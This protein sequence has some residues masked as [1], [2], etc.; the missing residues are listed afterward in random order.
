MMQKGNIRS[1]PGSVGQLGK[2]GAIKQSARQ[3]LDFD[4]E[5]VED[6]FI[7]SPNLAR[8]CEVSAATIL[9]Y[10]YLAYIA[11]PAEERRLFRLIRERK[12]KSIVELGI[13]DGSRACR[14][15]DLASRLSG[16]SIRYAGIDLFEARQDTA[17]GLRYKDAHQLLK[18]TGAKARLVP[19][20]PLTALSRAANELR[21]TDLLIIAADQNPQSLQQAWFYLP[22][23]LAPEGIVCQQQTSAD[24]QSVY[25]VLSAQQ[26]GELA[27]SESRQ[28]A[29]AAA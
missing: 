23:M 6:T 24:G 29:A 19:G 25:Q 17:T 12:V 21:D 22:R 27:G 11:K 20:D 28:F 9:R 3:S 2:Q 18:R 1:N 26:V 4:E 8:E 7:L 13:G 10:A 14:M 16:Q 15:I 5:L